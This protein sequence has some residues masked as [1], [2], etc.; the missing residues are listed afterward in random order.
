MEEWELY[1]EANHQNFEQVL[2]ELAKRQ[3]FL[4]NSVAY[5]PNQL[6]KFILPSFD[7]G[8]DTNPNK[9]QDDKF[10]N[11]WRGH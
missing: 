10:I 2:C 8:K 3:F 1:K 7:H 9:V 5:L 4:Q 6:P 11:I